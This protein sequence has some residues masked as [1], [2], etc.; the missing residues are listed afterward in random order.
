MFLFIVI[1]FWFNS[2]SHRIT[3]SYFPQKSCF[4]IISRRNSRNGRNSFFRLE[5][6]SG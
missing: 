6:R 3:C 5:P 4:F 1:L 2:I